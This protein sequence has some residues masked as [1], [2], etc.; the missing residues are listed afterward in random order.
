MTYCMWS[1]TECTATWYLQTQNCLDFQEMQ[2]GLS[3]LIRSHQ[4]RAFVH[5]FF[6]NAKAKSLGVEEF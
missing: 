4:L 3:I 6:K 5:Y 2:Y 1:C